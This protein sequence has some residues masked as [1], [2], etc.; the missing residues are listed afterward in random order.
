MPKKFVLVGNR[1][2]IMINILILNELYF[3]SISFKKNSFLRKL[4]FNTF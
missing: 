2:K 1:Q 4:S 3:L